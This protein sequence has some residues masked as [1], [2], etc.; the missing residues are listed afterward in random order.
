MSRIQLLDNATIDKIAAGEVVE[1]PS[2]VVKEL[3]ENAIDAGATAVTIEIK[4][5][6]ISFLRITDNGSG[7]PADQVREAFLR[8]A[9]SKIRT[10]E[11]LNNIHSLGFRGEALSSI[12]AVAQ[13]EMMTKTKDSLMGVHYCAEGGRETSFS[14]VGVPD[15]T[16]ILVKN[17][18]FNT[19]ARRKFLKTA[20]TEGGYIAD[21]CE[22][23]AMSKPEVSFK[24]IANNQV[25]FHT[26]GN[27]DIREIIYRIFGKDFMREIIPIDCKD[28]DIHIQGFLGKPALNRSN[29][30]FENCFINGRYVKSTFLF[31]AIEEGYRSFLMQHKFPFAVLYFTIDTD[32]VDVNVHP[33]KMDIRITDSAKYY[34]FIV[35]SISETLRKQEMIPDME[36]AENLSKVPKREAVNKSDVP[37]P[38]EQK[39]RKE[40]KVKEDFSYIT[41]KIFG[42]DVASN[43]VLSNHSHKNTIETKSTDTVKNTSET[44]SADIVMNTSEIKSA[45]I[46]M[47]T[48]EIKPA[49]T[50]K[51]SLKEH[52]QP[53]QGITVSSG[54]EPQT[55]T[56]AP[57]ESI[58]NPVQMNFFEERI[59]KQENRDKFE[60]LGQIFQTYW[61]VRYEEQLLF[62][63]Q[64]AAHEKVKYERLI[65]SVKEGEILSQT[66]QPPLVLHLTQKE[67]AALNEYQDYFENIGFVWEDFGSHSIAMRQMPVELYGKSEK[68]FFE[69]ILDELV[70]NG[71]KGTPDVVLEK[72]ASMACKSAVKGN[73]TMNHMEMKDLLEQLFE[74]ENPYHCPHGRPTMISMSKTDLEKKFK[75]IV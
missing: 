26:S 23:L 18:F 68:K 60:I 52:S 22:H 63:D 39:R 70:E 12:A 45:D 62:V 75:R 4:D 66:L 29:R 35:K 73:Q 53:K 47:N 38:F 31:K 43:P 51:I 42:E 71:C 40:Y 55:V 13:V 44:K 20:T 65:K 41:K 67:E 24:F 72:I 61:L 64:H 17:I 3:V 15:G 36:Q 54:K 10:S 74:L 69:E 37:E 57:N 25:K 48:S 2:S 9:T 58:I 32:K 16:T 1:R 50:A 46:V 59:L 30:N 5:G 28:E 27:G 56:S 7:I 21:L 34:H 19:P 33:T 11:D 49:D 8:H 14:Q 6:G